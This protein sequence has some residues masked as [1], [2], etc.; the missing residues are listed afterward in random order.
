MIQH[1]YSYTILHHVP[2]HTHTHTH[3]RA[4]ASTP[5]QPQLP[6]VP[7]WVS[8]LFA[9]WD[10]KNKKRLEVIKIT[11]TTITNKS[12]QR[13]SH[14]F[15]RKTH[16]FHTSQCCCRNHFYTGKSAWSGYTPHCQCTGQ[17]LRCSCCTNPQAVR[18]HNVMKGKQA[19]TKDRDLL[20][21]FI[22]ASSRLNH[23]TAPACKFSGLHKK[24]THTRL[25]TV[26]WMVL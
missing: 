17:L 13:N 24:C 21:S 12:L 7:Y 1:L 6:T 10:K 9:F 22:T 20:R 23:L 18:L 26:Y 15:I 25:Q 3:A 19:E 5:S 14:C 8:L 2:S 11:I 4:R 16:V